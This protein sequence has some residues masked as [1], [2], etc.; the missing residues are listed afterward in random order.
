[1]DGMP[2]VPP[3][4]P[5]LRLPQAILTP[6]VAWYSEE[7]SQEVYAEGPRDVVRVL[8]GQRPNSIANPEVLRSPALR[9]P[10]LREG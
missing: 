7:A 8:H 6:H 10:E 5:L 3:E 9:V 4:H 1:V 2:P